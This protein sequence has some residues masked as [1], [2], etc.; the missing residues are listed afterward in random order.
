MRSLQVLR[1]FHSAVVTAYRRRDHELRRLGADETL[2]VPLRW[3][4]GGR[5]V[6]IELSA[7]EE[8]WV[9]P[10]KS[11][12]RHPY[13]FI[14]DPL[15]LVRAMRARPQILD[16]HEEPASLAVAEVLAIAKLLRLRSPLLL[17]SA[18]NIFKRYPVPFRWIERSALR[19]ASA[20]YCCNTEAAEVLRR[21][22]FGGKAPVIPL[23]VD[24][25][26]F[27]P[28]EPV[29]SSGV[30]AIVGYVGRLEHHKGVQV[31]LDAMA[32]LPEWIVLEIVG[33][34]PELERLRKLAA[35]LGDRVSFR[36]F[37][38]H[39]ELPELYRQFD[40]VVIPSI[41]TPRWKEQFGR[42]AVEAMSSGVPIVA[43]ADGSLPEVVG[44][45]GLLVPPGDAPALAAVVRSVCEDKDTSTRLA[46]AGRE[47][48]LQY[49][50]PAV[51]ERHFALYEEVLS[52]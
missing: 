40:V 36:R 14:Y 1:V 24:V 19:R 48:A 43:S 15:A 4:E 21:K 44:P 37:V 34:G 27:S 45:G 52:S 10:I 25:D 30:N 28:R 17:Y 11:W 26:R 20:V 23:G 16:I 50:W 3:N 13:R 51:A 6:D 7:E 9:V 22:G 39:R 41:P 12:G 8:P 47:W 18:Q 35:P 38:D 49:A 42:V 33:D 2:L 5:D 31:L 29:R 46:D 32:A